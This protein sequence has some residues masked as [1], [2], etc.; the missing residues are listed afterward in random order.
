MVLGKESRFPGC[1]LRLLNGSHRVLCWCL[2]RLCLV[3]RSPVY[4]RADAGPARAPSGLLVRTAHIEEGGQNPDR[5]KAASL[6]Y[7]ENRPG[8]L[9]AFTQ[10]NS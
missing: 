3:P 5:L 6:P 2:K 7:T 10:G 9:A 4:R 1:G 8:T